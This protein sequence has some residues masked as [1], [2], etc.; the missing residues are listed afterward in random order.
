MGFEFPSRGLVFW[1]VCN[2][3]STTIVIDADTVVQID[4]HH[5][6]KSEDDDDPSWSVVDELVARLPKK[7]N[8]PYLAAFAL[9]HPDQDH[10]RGF[11]KLMDEVDIGELWFTPRVFFEYHADLCDD[12]K[13]FQKEAKRRVNATICAGGDPGTRNRVRLFGYCELLE[14][15]EFKGFPDNRLIVPGNALTIVDEVDLDGLFR[16]FVHSPFKDDSA[17]E[18][19]ETSLGLQVTLSDGDA[20]LR[21]LLFGDLAYPTLKRIF[22]VSDG[23]D[24]AWN[25]L[26]A[27]HH[28]S[29]KVMYWRDQGDEDEKL[30]QD[31]LDK[32]EAA[33][34]TPNHIVS[35]SDSIPAS[36]SNGDNPPHA[37][38]KSRYEG[39]TT[40]GFICTMEHPNTEKPEP[41]TFKLENGSVKFAGAVATA[42]SATMAATI[43]RGANPAP[44][45][46]VTYGKCRKATR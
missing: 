46:A 28:C 33:A 36:N 6:G 11:Q 37:K 34:Q 16:A 39:I 31:I 42:K 30:K 35:S 23:D 41:V 10:I 17:G 4:L 18:R 43:A 38:A 26:L 20:T 22:E 13:V 25:V 15:D 7:G 14:D 29:K 8:R 1:P 40:D 19:N 27:P 2:G 3:D 44:A 5:L 21:A 45:E 9:T 24:L 32:M 12:A